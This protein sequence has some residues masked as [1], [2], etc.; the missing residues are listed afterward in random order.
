IEERNLLF[1][2]IYEAKIDL[3]NQ[4]DSEFKVSLVRFTNDLIKIKD[5][6]REEN[7]II[8]R[9]EV[10]SDI[11]Y[12]TIE[13]RFELFLDIDKPSKVVVPF[14]ALLSQ[15]LVQEK[16]LKKKQEPAEQAISPLP[17]AETVQEKIAPKIDLSC[18]PI[19]EVD[20]EVHDFGRVD[21]GKDLEATF[22]LSNTGHADLII[23]HVVSGCGCATV[24]DLTGVTIPPGESTDLKVKLITTGKALD[25]AKSIRIFSNDPVNEVKS[26][27]VK[28]YIHVDYL[29][30][31]PVVKFSDFREGM[32][33]QHRIRI[34]SY[35]DKPLEISN[36]QS[37]KPYVS[38][39]FGHEESVK[40]ENLHYIDVVIDT[41]GYPLEIGSIYGRVK[42]QTNSTQ[43]PEGFF[44]FIIETIEDI[45]FTPRKIF[46]YR[47]SKSQ[48]EEITVTLTHV[49]NQPFS[50]KQ[51]IA[52]LEC[53]QAT[54]LEDGTDHASFVLK[55]AETAEEGRY[56]SN[57]E[58][59]LEGV[60]QTKVEIPL[61][62]LILP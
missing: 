58:I 4:T 15:S 52:G 9:Y 14:K 39:T 57:M 49:L 3:V 54:V 18:C 46:L 50:I 47:Y 26:I 20:S 38:C 6:K 37:D 19:I 22:A 61:T 7:T 29:I 32:R 44:N 33:D 45:K 48:K 24:N 16:L 13:G 55:L 21:Q 56:R 23:D 62:V 25:L 30:K 17:I 53:V 59:L 8:I 42:F 60:D 28:A 36:F 11:Q 27:Q 12:D 31:E 40:G 10:R 5:W 51:I 43:L 34:Q 2:T 35:M 1:D 41:H